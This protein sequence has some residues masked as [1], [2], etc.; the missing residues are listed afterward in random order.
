MTMSETRRLS[1]SKA[2]ASDHSAVPAAV[3]KAN[4]VARDRGEALPTGV[5]RAMEARFGADFSKVRIHADRSAAEAS[6]GLNARALTLGRHIAFNTGEYAPTQQTGQR[7]LAHELA[8]VVQQQ[9]QETNGVAPLGRNV[10]DERQADRAAEAAIS[11]RGAGAGLRV[12][13]GVRIQADDKSP[14]DKETGAEVAAPTRVTFVLRA[15]DDAYTQDVA[16]YVEN[17]L[18]EKVV[19][20]NNLDEAADYLARQANASKSKIGSVRIIGHGSTTGGIKMTPSGETGRRFVSAEELEK[21]AT[22]KKLKA[23]A[24]GAMADGATVEFWGCYIGANQRSTQAVSDIFE[25]DVKAIDETLRTIHDSFLRAADKGETGQKIKGQKGEWVETTSTAEIDERVKAG[26]KNLGQS[27]DRWLLAQAR[28]LEAGGDMP[29][30]QNDKARIAAMRDLF[31]RSGGKIK[32]LEIKTDKGTT[33]R[34]DGK[35]WLDHW[36]TTKVK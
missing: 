23:K 26:N 22:D 19:R 25:S 35:K 13:G 21:M 28:T 1:P 5:R 30:Q 34:S 11:E 33:R 4:R 16:D 24:G 18:N 6:E 29:P 12:G 14:K 7:L 27:F 36:K 20:V 15:P 31:D 32:R 10:A 17:T 8:H 3:S 9:A 2:A